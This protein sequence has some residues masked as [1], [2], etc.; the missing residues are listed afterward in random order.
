MSFSSQD[1]NDFQDALNSFTEFEFSEDSFT[2]SMEEQEITNI[3]KKAVSDYNRLLR[4][5]I[6]EGLE[7][8]EVEQFEEE[9]Y[10]TSPSIS[11]RMEILA[12]VQEEIK[13]MLE[14][15][16]SPPKDLSNKYSEDL[17]SR[18]ENC[19]IDGFEVYED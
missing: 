19:I 7:Y 16:S 13:D 17:V 9:Y 5:C 6:R 10:N 8:E 4:K 1:D 3:F 15:C 2:E 14:S 12:S 11:R 18:I